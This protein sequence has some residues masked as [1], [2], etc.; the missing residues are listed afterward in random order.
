MLYGG[1]GLNH[2]EGGVGDDTLIGG[3]ESDTYVFNLGDGQDEIRDVSYGTPDHNALGYRDE[4]VFGEGI[5]PEDIDV[6]HVGN[7]L[8]LQHRNGEDSIM[9]TD[10][11]VDE[12]NWIERISFANGTVWG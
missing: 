8:L 5:T 6:L 12:V 9:I 2:L 1:T 4:L 10:W 7:D 11:F 3:L